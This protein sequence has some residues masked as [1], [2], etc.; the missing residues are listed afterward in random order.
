MNRLQC[1][2]KKHAAKMSVR[3]EQVEK[4]LCLVA[5][6]FTLKSETI[7]QTKKTVM[8]KLRGSWSVNVYNGMLDNSDFTL[9]HMF[10]RACVDGLKSL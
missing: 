3:Q 1:I 10:G 5:S 8:E 6:K 7:A 4:E 2:V 9:L